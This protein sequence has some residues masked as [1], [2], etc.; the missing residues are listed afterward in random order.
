VFAAAL[1]SAACADEGSRLA[2]IRVTPEDASLASGLD[3]QLAAIG[4][5]TD[6][7]TRD[8]TARVAWGSPDAALVALGN[9]PGT[10]GLA[11]G[12]SAGTALVEA[13][14]PSGVRG[15][16]SLFVTAPLLT[17]LEVTPP[18]PSIALG[19]SVQLTAMGLYTD[20]T[21]LD[22]SAA[23]VWSSSD[24]LVAGVGA[25]PGSEGLASGLAVGTVTIEALDAASG[26]AG[27]A[28]LTVTAAVLVAI[29]VAPPAPSIALGTSVQ[30]TALGHFS[31]GTLQDL[32]ASVAWSSTDP[33]VAGV[34][35]AGLASGLAV[36]GAAIE[37]LDAASGIAGSA[38]LTVTPAVL[39]SIEVTPAAPSIALGTDLQLVATGIYSDASV[40]DLT[41]S[42]LWD[43]SDRSVASVSA[44]LAQSLAEGATAIS[45]TDPASGIGGS[46]A[47]TVTAAV[48][49]SVALSPAAPS[50]ALG[51]AVQF[52]AQGT[53]SDQST[54]DLTAEL[55]WGSSDPAV[56]SVSNAPGS[57][58]LAAG[59]AVGSASITA[60]DPASGIGGSETLTV[61][62]AALTA[63]AVSPSDPA[64]ALGT[65]QAFTATGSFTDGSSQDLTGAVTWSSSDP[66]VAA[67]SNAPGS[68]GQATGAGIGSA[69]ITALDPGSGISGSTTLS[70]TA[71]VLVSIAVA[72]A[73]SV[74]LIAEDL[75][76]AATGDFSDGGQQ[77]LTAAVL[78]S[79]SDP[80]VV[81]VSNAPGSQ[82]LA[83]GL[84]GGT[85]AI[86]ATDPG[87]SIAGSTDLS[88]APDIDLRSASSATAASGVGL[89]TIATPAGTRPGDVM[90]AAIAV[91]PSSAVITPPASS[92]TLARRIDNAGGNTNSLA[93]YTRVAAPGEAASHSWSFSTSTGSAG[94]IAAF[95]G[96]DAAS[97]IDVEAGAATPSGLS[98][99]TP[100]LTTAQ[101]RA[102]LVT[103]HAF[104]SSD[105][106]TPPAGM[107]EVVD[108]AS[109]AVP[110]AAGIALEINWVLQV[111]AG[112]TG[113]KSASA[114]SN[115]D[116]GTAH[117]LALVPGS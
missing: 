31:D 66:G 40:Q 52:A 27:T 70:V 85:A 3:L 23:V 4:T 92:W 73:D 18:A 110:N 49:E 87:S 15:S 80:A 74:V 65:A 114:G 2:S 97:P 5:Y 89:L 67:V 112:A 30:L 37:A 117:I 21:L 13:V 61:T 69:V 102:V 83:T 12:L 55:T 33:A 71:A 43:S 91:R 81:S 41:A 9:S 48:L 106:W 6:G 16:T 44:G 77:D 10:H 29:E 90:V 1:G 14:H 26:I 104:T 54:Q 22:Q 46:T 51:T 59:A 8:L 108:V 47:L 109:M 105:T 79:S 75:Q 19:T 36:G 24:P 96:V 116:T 25:L 98:H 111:A 94:G 88:V 50:I 99:A 57:A 95:S 60:L 76:L 103:S 72:P 11:S 20:S 107:T 68:A 39:V 93:V 38:A 101:A 113:S 86:T 53:F 34:D 82:G 84:A 42:A 45:A 32:S 100:G 64:V 58:G 7:R 56:A 35:A 78:W 28:S 115:A 63:I 17:A 62:A